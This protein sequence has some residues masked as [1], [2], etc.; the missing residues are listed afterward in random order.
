VSSYAASVA[1]N[2]LSAKYTREGSSAASTGV[3]KQ[4]M[5]NPHVCLLYVT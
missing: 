3:R 2:E 4:E 5:R 1:V